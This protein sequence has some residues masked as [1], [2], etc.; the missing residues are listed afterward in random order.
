VMMGDQCN[1]AEMGYSLHLDSGG[2][3]YLVW[4]NEMQVACHGPSYDSTVW[5]CPGGTPYYDTPI[6]YRVQDATGSPS[7]DWKFYMNCADGS[8]WHLA[9]ALDNG[10]DDNGTPMGETGRREQV[11]NATGMDDD[12]SNLNYRQ[13]GT[14]GHAWNYPKCYDD[15]YASNNWQGVKDASDHYHTVKGSG[16]C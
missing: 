5:P 1:Q 8:G 7:F 13:N 6:G 12:Q 15:P 2:L 4:F 14:W 3:K 11:Q 16:S 9:A 10:P